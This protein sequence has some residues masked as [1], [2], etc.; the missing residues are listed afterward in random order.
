MDAADQNFQ[1]LVNHLD[2]L[3]FLEDVLDK[4]WQIC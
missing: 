3:L 2:S 4:F 1:K